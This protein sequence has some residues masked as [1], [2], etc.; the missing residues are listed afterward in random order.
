MKNC[1]LEEALGIEGFV[2]VLIMTNYFLLNCV[3]LHTHRNTL[4]MPNLGLHDFNALRSPWPHN[5][6]QIQ[7]C[8]ATDQPDTGLC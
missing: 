5:L 7:C 8:I 6:L 4:M 1:K 3:Y 2:M